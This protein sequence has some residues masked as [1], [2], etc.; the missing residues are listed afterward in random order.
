MAGRFSGLC[1]IVL[2][3]HAMSPRLDIVGERPEAVADHTEAPVFNHSAVSRNEICKALP[4]MEGVTATIT[5]GASMRYLLIILAACLPLWAQAIEF[6]EHVRSLALGRALQVF[7]DV[8]GTATIESVS[9]PA[10]TSAFRPLEGK[11]FNAGYSR[12]AFWLKGDLLYRP[13]TTTGPMDWILELAYPPLDRIDLYLPDSSGRLR[14]A[15]QTGD[16]LPFASRPIKQSNYL[17]DLDLQPDK[18]MTFY[19]RVA[20]DGPVQAPLNLWSSH[21]FIERQPVQLQVMGLIYGVLLGMLIYN[22]FIFFSV[23]DRS[24]LYFILYI[25]T[26]GL[27]QLSISGTA[28]EYLWPDSPWWA[29]AATPFLMG[30]A[31]L[32]SSLFSR[33]FLQTARLARWLDRLIWVLMSCAI[34]VMLLA[35]F[36]NYGIALRAATALVMACT[37]VMLA[38]G[39]TA[40]VKGV[41]SARYYL[42]G[43]VVFYVGATINAVMLLGYLP[44]TFFILYVGHMGAVLEMAFLSL[45]LADRQNWIR[46]EQAQTLVKA[47]ADLEHLNKQLAAS[48]RHKDEFL[49]TLTHEL[50]TPMNGVIGSLELMKTV[51]MDGEMKMYQQTA[52]SSAQDMMGMINGILTLS[53]LQAGALYAECE[54]FDPASLLGRLRQRFVEP[55]RVKGL[56]FRLELDETL[57]VQLR[58]DAAKLYQCVECL[59]DNAIKFT[60]NGFVRLRASGRLYDVDRVELCV[61]VMDTGI[62][63]SPLDEARLYQHFFQ[64]D[65]SMTREHGGLGI[66]LA[67]CRKLAELQGGTLS[68]ESEPGKGSC[69]TLSLPL[70]IVMPGALH[71]APGSLSMSELPSRH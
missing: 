39:V 4:P 2:A 25:A 71:K 35:L 11:T 19:L 59:V 47:G 22:L 60:D 28:I 15:S 67:I 57:P 31:V 52:A 56:D 53:E 1:F 16:Q 43:W 21:A 42:T 9:A 48:N 41:R 18:P 24:Y 14:L 36:S 64:I 13:A 69:F 8:D 70:W 33:S 45:A 37:W 30:T 5:F 34:G 54:V 50:R 17:F 63:F 26:F 55:A 23:R 7:E 68:H 12:S 38:C 3:S 46:E 49:A 32:F 66:G 10:N 61:E 51:E 44:N 27:Y 29:N 20:S 62:G 65:G 58:G 40:V 6:D